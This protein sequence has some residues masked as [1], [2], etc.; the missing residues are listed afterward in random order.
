MTVINKYAFQTKKRNKEFFKRKD[1][2]LT[3]LDWAKWAGW[4]DTDGCFTT[5]WNKQRKCYQLFVDLRL[6]DKA[7]VE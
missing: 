1:R 3:N 5:Q 6:H 7:P 4:F 2:E